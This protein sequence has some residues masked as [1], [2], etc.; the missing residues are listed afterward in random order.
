M[1]QKLTVEA[2]REGEL[3][4]E[5]ELERVWANLQKRVSS[6]SEKKHN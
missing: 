5:K 4:D 1:W 6:F 3:G 2:S